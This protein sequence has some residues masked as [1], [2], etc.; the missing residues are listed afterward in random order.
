MCFQQ[1]VWTCWEHNIRF[2]PNLTFFLLYT[3]NMSR[4]QKMKRSPWMYFNC[5]AMILTLNP[6]KGGLEQLV[7]N[8][9]NF[10]FCSSVKPRTTCQKFT[11]VSC[12]SVN[13]LPYLVWTCKSSRLISWSAPEMRVW[14]W[15]RADTGSVLGALCWGRKG[16]SV[17]L[18]SV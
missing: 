4:L 6:N 5:S 8:F 10:R 16:S 11:I 2:E 13:P 1:G 7:T 17:G 9:N 14:S 15:S 3:K 12:V 18:E